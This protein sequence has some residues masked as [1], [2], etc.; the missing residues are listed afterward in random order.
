METDASVANLNFIPDSEQSVS[1]TS[2]PKVTSLLERSEAVL[3]RAFGDNEE[4]IANS[5]RGL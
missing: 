3:R 1:D 4:T 2:K 5:L